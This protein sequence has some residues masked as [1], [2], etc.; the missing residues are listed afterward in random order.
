MRQLFT[1]GERQA[2]D[3]ARGGFTTYYSD[4]KSL[5]DTIQ[6]WQK[7]NEKLYDHSQP[8]MVPVAELWKHREY[9]WT[10]DDARMTS[11][12][13]D[14]LKASL[15]RGW[16][17]KHWIYIQVG[18]KGGVKVG[19]GNHRLSIAR[20]IGLRKLPV[21]IDFYTGRVTKSPQH[22]ETVRLDKPKV[23]KP[24]TRELTKRH[25]PETP[26]EKAAMK[27]DVDDIMKLLGM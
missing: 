20:E 10:R 24:P 19:E 1:E 26:E 8:V 6:R 23:V 5:A 12:E 11:A 27:R 4:F 3:E 17:A 16:D 21:R 15:K 9:T 13:W 14:M 25:E 18:Q 22:P 2:L 7:E